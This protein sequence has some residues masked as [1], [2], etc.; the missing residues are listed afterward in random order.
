MSESNDDE[1]ESG[2]GD[3]LSGFIQIYWRNI[4]VS[5]LF[6]L[7]CYVMFVA[8]AR[9]ACTGGYSIGLKCV[10]PAAWPLV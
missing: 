2:F 5:A 4:L 1:I 10:T 7:L 8:G 6:V 9:F 3:W